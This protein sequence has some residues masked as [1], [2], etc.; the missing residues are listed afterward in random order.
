IVAF[1]KLH[2]DERIVVAR[3]GDDRSPSSKPLDIY[4]VCV[5]GG[6]PSVAHNQLVVSGGFRTY[7]FEERDWKEE[8][9]GESGIDHSLEPDRCRCSPKL[10]QEGG[11]K[12]VVDKP[13]QT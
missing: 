3:V 4:P 13:D 9:F 5:K 2:A 6:R 10:D 11:L 7:R 12:Q 1:E 8:E